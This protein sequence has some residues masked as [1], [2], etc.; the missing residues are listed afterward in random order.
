MEG[1]YVRFKETDHPIWIRTHQFGMKKISNGYSSC[2]LRT[3][4]TVRD[5][6][7]AFKTAVAPDLDG[8]LI[9]LHF[10]SNGEAVDLNCVLA[11]IQLENTFQNPL[12]IKYSSPPDLVVSSIKSKNSDSVKYGL[13]D[14][15]TYKSGRELFLDDDSATDFNLPPITTVTTPHRLIELNGKSY[16]IAQYRAGDYVVHS[17]DPKMRDGYCGDEI[18]FLL[19]TGYERTVKGPYVMDSSWQSYKALVAHGMS[20]LNQQACKLTVG[21]LEATEANQ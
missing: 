2:S 5:A 16:F 18:C 15:A 6:I 14:S 21:T 20:E 4:F 17:W 11:A 8:C 12:Y 10:E 7:T 13:R 19:D 3:L 1:L 9:T